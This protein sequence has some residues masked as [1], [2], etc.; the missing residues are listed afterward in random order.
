ML[1]LCSCVEATRSSPTA[2]RDSITRRSG[3]PA[4]PVPPRRASARRAPEMANRVGMK[5]LS[6][7]ARSPYESGSS[8][9]GPPAS[10]RRRPQCRSTHEEVGAVRSRILQSHIRWMVLVGALALVVGTAL[11][12][13][14]DHATRPHTRNIQALGH[15]P[16]PGSFLVPDGQRTVNSDIAFWGNLAFNGNYDGFRIIDVSE[17]GDPQL[18]S[19]THCNGD[20]GDIAVWQNILVRSWNSKKTVARDCD[21]TTVPAGWE[22]VH[23]FDISD[24]SDPKVSAAVELP[25]GSHTLTVAGISDGR[26]IVYS[27]NSSSSG[28]V[29]GTL[30]NDNPVGAFMDVIA[31]PLDNPAGS[32]LIHREPV[33]GPAD[34]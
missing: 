29:D 2:P 3:R 13:S 10:R 18:V 27:N 24:R 21:G 12:A 8:P 14:A 33:A 11:P 34:P 1:T 25:R 19:W 28:C 5:Q 9:R 32:S 31:V 22:G 20:Q 6:T 7:P 15:S 30:V 17:P 23:V 26:L 4:L 16:Q